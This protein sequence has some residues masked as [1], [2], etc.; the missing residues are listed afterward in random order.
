[1]YHSWNT[2]I[3]Q[4]TQ[5]KTKRA[6]PENVLCPRTEDEARWLINLWGD[7][8]IKAKLQGMATNDSLTSHTTQA[9]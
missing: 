9:S 8:Y 4:S 7:S 3:S 2:T 1:M 5:C 6:R